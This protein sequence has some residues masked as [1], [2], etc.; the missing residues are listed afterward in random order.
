MTDSNKETVSWSEHHA[1]WEGGWIVDLSSIHISKETY[2]E[3]FGNDDSWEEQQRRFFNDIAFFPAGMLDIA[4]IVEGW[5][6]E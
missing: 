4:Q 2:Q 6:D 3:Y 1:N 5:E